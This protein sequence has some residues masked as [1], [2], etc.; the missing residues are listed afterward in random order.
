MRD[1]WSNS[2][3]YTAVNVFVQEKLE[4]SRRMERVETGES[5]DHAD[6]VHH[7]T[8]RGGSGN[9]EWLKRRDV[10]REEREEEKNSIVLYHL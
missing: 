2:K 3:G 5:G 9:G 6:N 8:G 1:Q 10:P 7:R 4:S